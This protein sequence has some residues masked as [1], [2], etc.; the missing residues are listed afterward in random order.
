MSG[1]I[2]H[3]I[4]L[5][6]KTRKIQWCYIGKVVPEVITSQLITMIIQSG[7]NPESLN[8]S[9]VN[10]NNKEMQSRGSLAWLWRQTHDLE[11]NLL[12]N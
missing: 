12:T 2:A 3:Y 5:K 6:G 4:G 7:S 8:L 11:S 9:I 1:R 10:Q